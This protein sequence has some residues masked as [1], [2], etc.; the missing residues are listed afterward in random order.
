MLERA[1]APSQVTTTVPVPGRVAGP[2]SQICET[3]PL[4]CAVFVP[5]PWLY[6][7]ANLAS[8][9]AWTVEACRGLGAA[10]DYARVATG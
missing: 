2:M 6:G 10:V 1:L 5:G 4:A 8:S 7:G 3:E 9:A